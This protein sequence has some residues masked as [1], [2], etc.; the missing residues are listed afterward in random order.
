LENQYLVITA[1]NP[2]IQYI[3]SDTYTP[4]NNLK[5]NNVGILQSR[6]VSVNFSGATDPPSTL[7]VLRIPSQNYLIHFY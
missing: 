3:E 2:V 5:L 4:L 7:L 1:K 6:A